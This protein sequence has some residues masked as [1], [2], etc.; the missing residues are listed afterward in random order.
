MFNL[1]LVSTIN[2]SPSLSPLTRQSSITCVTMP[3]RSLALSLSHPS[4]LT[5]PPS[6]HPADHDY[7]VVTFRV[8]GSVGRYKWAYHTLEVLVVL[9]NNTRVT[10]RV[11]HLSPECQDGEPSENRSPYLRFFIDPVADINVSPAECAG[12][13]IYLCGLGTGSRGVVAVV[14]K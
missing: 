4:S 3:R 7:V 2:T 5:C 1:G 10:L 11:A 8:A 6:P 14:P 13:E 12:A 9:T